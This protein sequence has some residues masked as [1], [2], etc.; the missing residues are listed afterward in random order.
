MVKL[1]SKYDIFDFPVGKRLTSDGFV[2]RVIWVNIE[3]GNNEFYNLGFF[4]DENIKK[5][6]EAIKKFDKR[7]P[8]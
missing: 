6:R 1:M 5:L 2:Q 7:C 4:T 3:L 8:D